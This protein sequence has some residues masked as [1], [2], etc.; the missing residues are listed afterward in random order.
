MI[1][2]TQSSSAATYAAQPLAPLGHGIFALDSGYVRPRFDAVHLMVEAGRAAIIDT[3][4]PMSTGSS[5]R[6]FT[7]ITRAARA[8]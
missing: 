5:S 1:S 6:M 4:P 7:W 2:P 8:L 3:S